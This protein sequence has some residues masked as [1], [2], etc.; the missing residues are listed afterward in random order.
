MTD[1]ELLLKRLALSDI[2]AFVHHVRG[3]LSRPA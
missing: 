2:E 3:R 1:E